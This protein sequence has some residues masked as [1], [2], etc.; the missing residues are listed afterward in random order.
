MV[1]VFSDPFLSLTCFIR[2][3]GAYWIFT[4]WSTFKYLCKMLSDNTCLFTRPI[5]LNTY[6]GM[7]QCIRSEVLILAIAINHISSRQN[8]QV[9]KDS[10]SQCL[11]FTHNVNIACL[12]EIKILAE[13]ITEIK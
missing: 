3:P 10:I 13:K 1:A 2:S 12:K 4:I 8:I 11:F 6:W 5:F 9:V 7:R